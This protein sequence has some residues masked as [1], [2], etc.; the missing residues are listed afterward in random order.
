MIKWKYLYCLKIAYGEIYVEPHYISIDTDHLSRYEESM[1][2]QGLA[3]WDVLK[4]KLM[5]ARIK[6]ILDHYREVL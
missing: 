3:Y 2:K 4:A 5:L 6:N 1:L